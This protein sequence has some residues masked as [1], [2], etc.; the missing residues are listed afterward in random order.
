MVKNDFRYY[1]KLSSTDRQTSRYN[2]GAEYVDIYG[3]KIGWWE[4]K[5]LSN[6]SGNPIKFLLTSKYHK[7]P[8]LV[9]HKFF[10]TTSLEWLILQYNNIVDIDE[11]FI[12]GKEILIPKFY[13]IIGS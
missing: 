2:I 13:D 11:E 4:R 7:R 1:K 8:D 6:I 12:D 3:D 9:S 5:D 10:G